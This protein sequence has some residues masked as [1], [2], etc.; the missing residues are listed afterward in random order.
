MLRALVWEP[1]RDPEILE[2]VRALQEDTL[3]SLLRIG[4][5]AYLVWHA[6]SIFLVE[7]TTWWRYWLLALV[8]ASTAAAT[9]ALLRR[10]SAAA[11]PAFVAGCAVSALAAAWIFRTPSPLLFLPAAAVAAVVLINPLAGVALAAGSSLGLLGLRA[12][13]PLAFVGPDRVS[14]TLVA[15]GLAVA[16]AWA[17]GRNMAIAVEWSLDS[18]RRALESARLARSQR[19]RIVHTLRQLD[20]AYEQLQHANAEL[21]MAWKAAEAA[22][23]SKTE[24]VTNISHELRTPLNLVTGDVLQPD[25][26][27]DRRVPDVHPGLRHDPGRPGQRDARRRWVD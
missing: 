6:A 8:V 15:S 18:Y 23:R 7:P 5:S 14:E 11:G 12:V 13:G 25:P 1:L 22:E 21:V 27:R 17:L 19:G 4:G 26:G 2:D 3:R 24:F 20:R 9:L 10:G 16:L